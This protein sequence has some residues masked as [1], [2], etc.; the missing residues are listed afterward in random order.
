ML[1]ITNVDIKKFNA[2]TRLKGVAS[3][4]INDCFVV[5]E[6]R[7]IDGKNGLTVVMPSRRMPNGEFKDMVRATNKET[8]NAIEHM[9]LRKYMEAE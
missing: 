2:Q 5:H 7:I 4:T 1:N 3:I 9:V 8:K 6:L